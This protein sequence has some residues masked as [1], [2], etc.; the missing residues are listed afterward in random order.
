M[1]ILHVVS[2]VD[3]EGSFGGP[4]RVAVNQLAQLRTAGHEVTLAAGVR[5]FSS[6]PT[7][8]DS[9]PLQAF[10]A[11]TVV[12]G[13][14]FAGISA[15]EMLIW[16]ARNA[17][18]FDVVHIHL[19]RDLVSLP[20]AALLQTMRIPYIVQTHGMIDASDKVLARVLDG[21]M[22]RRVLRSASTVLSLTAHE[23]RDLREVEPK[24]SSVVVLPNG[25]PATDLVGDAGGSR[26]VL[27]LARMAP[28]K[29]P[30]WFVRA[31]QQLAAEFPEYTFSLVGPDEG[32]GDPVR[33][34][35]ANDDAGGR[36]KY[37][38][39][40]PPSQTLERMTKSCL[41]VLPAIEE[42]FGMTVVE[43]MSV[44]LPA[45]VRDDCGIADDVA[46]I[47]GAVF[48]GD[49]CTAQM[50]IFLADEQLRREVG[51]RGRTFVAQHVTMEA[52]GRQLED[53]YMG[54]VIA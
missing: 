16:L 41:Y 25:V 15:P 38:G 26:D 7:E 35:L 53:V 10:Q 11:R 21:V 28:R 49:D 17:R 27:F 6:L 13:T 31:A 39:A 5:G 8:F 20:A 12:P 23:S 52:I 32:E 45:V 43:A 40:M 51:E 29:R 4:L 47:G 44:G 14:G 24:L 18:S 54:T 19:A 42:P 3:P 9:V 2:L 34:L 48:S 1:K 36:I 33:S 30:Q 22:T 50:R 46:K 37:E